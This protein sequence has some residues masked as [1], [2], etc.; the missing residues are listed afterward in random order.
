MTRMVGLAVNV[1]DDPLAQ[2]ERRHRHFLDV[3]RL[4]ISGDVVENPSRIASDDRVRGEIGQVGVNARG[5]R[6]I[7]SGSG[8]DVCRKGAALAAN[9]QR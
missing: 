6:M 4:R 5:H 3:A 9:D 1:F 8:V 7:I 2:R